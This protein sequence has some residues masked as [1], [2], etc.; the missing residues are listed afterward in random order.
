LSGCIVGIGIKQRD[1]HPVAEYVGC[2]DTQGPGKT[3]GIVVGKFE[4]EL[5]AGIVGCTDNH[6]VEARLFVE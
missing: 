5:V 3:R 2:G 6:G 1:K 4:V